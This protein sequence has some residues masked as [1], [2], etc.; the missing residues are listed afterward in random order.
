MKHKTYKKRRNPA[1]TSKPGKKWITAI[2]AAQKTLKRTHSVD[3]AKVSLER[4]ALTNARKMFG[5][6]GSM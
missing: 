4:Q 2:E 6:I 3:Q 1:T 5:A